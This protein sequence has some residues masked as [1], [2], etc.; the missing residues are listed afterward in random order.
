M[1]RVATNSF[2]WNTTYN[3]GLP[4]LHTVE[5]CREAAGCGAAGIEID[6]SRVTAAQLEDAGIALSGCPSEKLHPRPGTVA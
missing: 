6:L 5:T 4:E 1:I 3:E 2:S